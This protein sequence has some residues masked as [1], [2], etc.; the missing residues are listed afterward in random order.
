M[1]HA[2]ITRYP[3]KPNDDGFTSHPGD[4]HINSQDKVLTYV[5]NVIGW[6]QLPK[7]KFQEIIAEHEMREFLGLDIREEY[8]DF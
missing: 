1:E 4:F 5:N 6:R 8:G 7:A 2:R 3:R